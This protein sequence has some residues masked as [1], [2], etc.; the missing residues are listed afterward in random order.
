MTFSAASSSSTSISTPAQQNTK[1]VNLPLSSLRHISALR[2]QICP[3]STLP[4]SRSLRLLLASLPSKPPAPKSSS[5]PPV[6]LPTL[7]T[8][9]VGAESDMGLAVTYSDKRTVEWKL[10]VGQDRLVDLKTLLEK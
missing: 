9:V 6:T 3:T 5:A 10:G 4:S 8:R 7:E 2:L 1:M